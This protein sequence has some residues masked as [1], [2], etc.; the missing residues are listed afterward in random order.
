MTIILAFTSKK[1]IPKSA[2]GGAIGLMLCILICGSGKL[3][4][5]A[6]NPFR[7]LGPNILA[8]EFSP[9]LVFLTFPVLGSCFACFIFKVFIQDN[10]DQEEDMDKSNTIDDVENE[11]K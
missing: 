11:L 1:D 2:F 7:A 10:F 3:T 6:A 9:L 4:G 5:C 8:L